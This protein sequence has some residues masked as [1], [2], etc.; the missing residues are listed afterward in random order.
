MSTFK[1][2]N[3]DCDYLCEYIGD[4]KTFFLQR[5]GKYLLNGN[6]ERLRFVRVDCF[7]SL[8]RTFVAYLESGNAALVTPEG[9][10]DN[11]DVLFREI[12]DNWLAPDKDRTVNC[13]FAEIGARGEDQDNSRP[14]RLDVEGNRWTYCSYSP[15]NGFMLNKHVYN[16]SNVENVKLDQRLGV[17]AGAEFYCLKYS[18]SD[19]SYLRLCDYSNGKANYYVQYQFSNVIWKGS[20]ILG[21]LTKGNG[22]VV[23]SKKAGKLADEP[24]RMQFDF[25]KGMSGEKNNC[26][27]WGIFCNQWVIYMTAPSYTE[28]TFKYNKGDSI[29]YND[30]KQVFIRRNHEQKIT[31][32]YDIAL[33]FVDI[34]QGKILDTNDNLDKCVD[35]WRK[36]VEELRQLSMTLRSDEQEI[37]NEL[38]KESITRIQDSF[39]TDRTTKWKDWKLLYFESCGKDNLVR[40]KSTQTFFVVSQGITNSNVI[41]A[42][43]GNSLLI[44]QQLKFFKQTQ[45]SYCRLLYEIKDVPMELFEMLNQKVNSTFRIANLIEES[46]TPIVKQKWE[47]VNEVSPNKEAVELPSDV[48]V[49]IKVNSQ[50][51][52]ISETSSHDEQLSEP[53]KSFID[54]IEEV[55]SRNTVMTE[56]RC[57]FSFKTDNNYTEYSLCPFDT[58]PDGFNPF[59]IRSYVRKDIGVFVLLDDRFIVHYDF[60]KMDGVTYEIP[61]EGKDSQDI[62]DKNANRAIVDGKYVYLFYRDNKGVL[63]FFDQAIC[64][65][66]KQGKIDGKNVLRFFLEPF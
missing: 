18:D 51:T 19:N 7:D 3:T 20:Y 66:Y 62:M 26:F 49:D 17:I 47:D 34:L 44:G 29:E 31:A 41:L 9:Y 40:T 50:P 59:K 58:C 8:T 27:F 60:E 21:I 15:D 45:K 14:I 35:G 4:E 42:K 30:E 43:N 1:L 53:G 54:I 46:T 48:N 6:G 37:L 36:Y 22:H 57:S 63:H 13:R 24:I 5:S 32:I 39:P 12:S 64:R 56:K 11:C 61:G 55:Q 25:F 2:V 38:K 52:M 28:K 65:A 10:Y 33:S 23:V 16:Y